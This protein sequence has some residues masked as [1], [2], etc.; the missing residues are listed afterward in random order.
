MAFTNASLTASLGYDLISSR[1]PFSVFTQPVLVFRS[2]KFNAFS[3]TFA[4]EPLN[5]LLS[6]T[7][8][9]LFF[10]FHKRQHI[11]VSSSL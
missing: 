3:N 5:L 6:R 4:I 7:I 10:P 8:P 2:I 9:V 1:P 11:I